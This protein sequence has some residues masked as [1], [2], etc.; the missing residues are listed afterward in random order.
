MRGR[1]LGIEQFAEVRTVSRCLLSNI[2]A[3]DAQ[4][5]APEEENWFRGELLCLT[6][7]PSLCRASRRQQAKQG[8]V[9]T[10]DPLRRRMNIG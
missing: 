5:S 4:A 3:D 10:G 1:L 2:P 6:E 8:S 9:Y 7:P